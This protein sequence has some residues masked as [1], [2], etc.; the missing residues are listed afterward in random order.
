[1]RRRTSTTQTEALIKLPSYMELDDENDNYTK[2]YPSLSTESEYIPIDALV[3]GTKY[4]TEI[5]KVLFYMLRIPNT[6]AGRRTSTKTFS[7]FGQR[8]IGDSYTENRYWTKIN[9][10]NISRLYLAH[11][12][13]LV[14]FRQQEITDAEGN[15]TIFNPTNILERIPLMA[16]CM[17]K[18]YLFKQTPETKLNPNP[19]HFCLVIDKKLVSDPEHFKLYR[20]VKKHYI[21]IMYEK[22]DVV[23]VNSVVD[24]CYKGTMDIPQFNTVDEMLEYS[25]LMNELII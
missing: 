2:D 19:D 8:L 10:A 9:H 5:N 17:K 18:Q 3:N 7:I 15:L 6:N 11:I 22:V 14:W 16:L 1:M 21:D 23:Y 24:S 12:G 25:K 4:S 13:I 20:N